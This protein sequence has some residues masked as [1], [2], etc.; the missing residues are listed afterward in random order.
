MKSYV[1]SDLIVEARI[2]SRALHGQTLDALLHPGV[3]HDL[4][5]HLL[6]DVGDNAS[7]GWVAGDGSTVQNRTALEP[8]HGDVLQ[9]LD[10]TQPGRGRHT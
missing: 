1:G 5:L 6:P 9:W 10:G 2:D 7:H 4:V 3:M 8:R